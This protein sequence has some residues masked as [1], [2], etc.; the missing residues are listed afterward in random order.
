MESES[1]EGSLPW[2]SPVCEHIEDAIYEEPQALTR[3][4]ICWSTDHS[5]SSLQILK[6]KKQNKASFRFSSVVV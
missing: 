1:A 4:R 6:N 3:H 2:P 5:L